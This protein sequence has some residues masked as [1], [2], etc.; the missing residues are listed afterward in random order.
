MTAWWRG[1]PGAGD[2]EGTKMQT[3]GT[4]PQIHSNTRYGGGKKGGKK[5]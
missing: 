4:N 3:T 5:R 2:G 1:R